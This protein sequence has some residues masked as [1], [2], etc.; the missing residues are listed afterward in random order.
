MLQEQHGQGTWS[1]RSTNQ[2]PNRSRRRRSSTAYAKPRAPRTSPPRRRGPHAAAADA[3]WSR[4]LWGGAESRIPPLIDS[5]GTPGKWGS[6]LRRLAQPR[7]PTVR[8]SPRPTGWRV[9]EE[10]CPAWEPGEQVPGAP[11]GR[12]SRRAWLPL[13][14][15]TSWPR[16]PPQEYKSVT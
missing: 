15:V 12:S 16:A 13:P 3:H 7:A 5:H 2:D 14:S 10:C 1:V 9:T 6:V 11:H 8:S 4:A